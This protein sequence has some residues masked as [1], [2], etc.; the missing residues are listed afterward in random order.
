MNF[1]IGCDILSIV[2]CFKC[3]TSSMSFLRYII[4]N[5]IKIELFMKC[6]TLKYCIISEAVSGGI[7][8]ELMLAFTRKNCQLLY[9][10][11]VNLWP[12]LNLLGLH[13][14]CFPSL[15]W[16]YRSRN[17]FLSI[18]DRK[19]SQNQTKNSQNTTTNCSIQ[20]IENLS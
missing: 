17:S 15:L 3:R 5:F 9:F 10:I 12:T 16:Y 13:T 19:L 6:D 7:W 8:N 4:K 11:V 20:R 18:S 1:R 14:C 2:F